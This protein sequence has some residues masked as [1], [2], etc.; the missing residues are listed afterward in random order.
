MTGAASSSPSGI[1]LLGGEWAGWSC[2]VNGLT[3]ALQPVPDK[4]VSSEMIEWGQV[5]SGFETVTTEVWQGSDV[6]ERR[7]VTLLP[8]DG[9]NVE[10]LGA[11]VTREP[12]DMSTLKGELPSPIALDAVDEDGIWRCESI[13]GGFGGERPRT[14]RG[15]VPS[16]AERTRVTVCVDV[17]KGKL[18]EREPVEVRQERCWDRQ[19]AASASERLEGRPSPLALWRR[20]GA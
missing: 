20:Q 18:F 15:A 16:V 2:S 6:I 12:L 7:L 9:C 3:G 10:N 8:E 4:F 19:P 17:D 14:R 1:A 11:I 13:F 5:P